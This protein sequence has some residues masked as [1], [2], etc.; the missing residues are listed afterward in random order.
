MLDP[1]KHKTSAPDASISNP[2][3]G[4][5]KDFPATRSHRMGESSAGTDENVLPRDVPILS[6]E[7]AS[8]MSAVVDP[9]SLGEPLGRETIHKP[10]SAAT[11]A[12]PIMDASMHPKFEEGRDFPIIDPARLPVPGKFVLARNRPG[13]VV[14]RKYRELGMNEHGDMA[15]ELVPLNDDFATLH[16][17]RDGLIVIGTMVAYTHYEE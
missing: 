15:F 2:N 14:F 7:K 3:T 16:S 5:F 11:F 1:A 17:E 6:Y 10:F 4:L 12:V 13:G 9:W 8:Q